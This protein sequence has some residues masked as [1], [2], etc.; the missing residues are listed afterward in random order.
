MTIY[1][2]LEQQDV[3]A[4]QIL[5][6][7]DFEGHFDLL[8]HFRDEEYGLLAEAGHYCQAALSMHVNG[9]AVDVGPTVLEP[10]DVIVARHVFL[11]AF[12]RIRV[13]V[14]IAT[15]DTVW[16]VE[17]PQQLLHYSGNWSATLDSDEFDFRH[18]AIHVVDFPAGAGD[19]EIVQEV[20]LAQPAVLAHDEETAES[21]PTTPSEY[22]VPIVVE[23]ESDTEEAEFVD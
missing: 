17:A 9:T 7:A 10:C 12:Y 14:R 6:H 5:I 2:Q 19:V 11:R 4:G 1:A 22:E 15:L 20:R 13:S 18:E 21:R 8:E 16:R 23:A 3:A